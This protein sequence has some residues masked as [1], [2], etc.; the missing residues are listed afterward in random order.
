MPRE[1]I[2][3]RPNAKDDVQDPGDPDELLGECARECEVSPREDER[4]D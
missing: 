1:V 3:R 4:D 2:D